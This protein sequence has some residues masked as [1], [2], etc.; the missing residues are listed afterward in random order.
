MAIAG[1]TI[2]QRILVDYETTIWSAQTN[3]T[4][5]RATRIS[6]MA[7]NL[8]MYCESFTLRLRNVSVLPLAPL[9]NV[10]G[11]PVDRKMRSGRRGKL[12]ASAITDEFCGPW[13]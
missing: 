5:L 6:E 1:A 3:S 13:S 11:S 4:K 2:P 10:S 9:L 12:A 7:S 8:R